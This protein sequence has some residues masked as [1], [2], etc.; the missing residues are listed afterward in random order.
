MGRTAKWPAYVGKQ[1]NGI[2]ILGRVEK[3]KSSRKW[4]KLKCRCHCGK[5]FEP[6]F[7]HIIR[8]NTKSCG[9]LQKSNFG[10][11]HHQWKGCGAI[12]GQTWNV[13]S[14]LSRKKQRKGRENLPFEITIEEAW[15]LYLKQDCKC[16]LSGVPIEFPKTNYGVRTASLDRIDCK[17]GYVLENVQWVHKDVNRMKNV[18]SQDYF[19]ETCRRI[20]E[21]HLR[22]QL[23]EAA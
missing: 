7:T 13:I 5:Y 17:K 16:A 19:L 4:T 15:E 20:A 10:Q 14:G 21:T 11:F 12:S 3:D 22:K 2:T 23:A 1:I 18:Y 9:C 6:W 8:G